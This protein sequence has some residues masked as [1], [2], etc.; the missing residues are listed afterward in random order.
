MKESILHDEGALSQLGS[1]RQDL[2]ACANE[3]S[4]FE[5]EW[6]A[7]LREHDLLIQ[8]E[9]E[10]EGRVSTAESILSKRDETAALFSRYSEVEESLGVFSSALVN[11]Q[12]QL[13]EGVVEAINAALTELWPALYPYQDFTLAKVLVQDNDYVLT[14]RERSGAWIPAESTLSGGERSAAALALRMAIAF[15]LTRQ[16]S[17]IILD[18]PTHNLDSKSVAS[19]SSLLRERLPGLVDQ[20][21]VITHSPEIERA[22]TGSLYVMNRQK[23]E[24]GAT[25][26]E[27]RVIDIGTRVV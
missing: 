2:D 1:P 13:R 21:F 9:R 26:P 3:W 20:V 19:L 24:D 5:S 11:T 7:L 18:E 10:L 12:Q 6:N 17:W 25:F 27:E 16:L 22:A 8:M 15:V 23:D 4:R 14:L